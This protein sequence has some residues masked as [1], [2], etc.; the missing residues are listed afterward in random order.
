MKLSFLVIDSR[1]DVHSNWVNACIQSLMSM[2]KNNLSEE[3]EIVIVPN[4]GR[5]MTIG[6]AWNKGVQECTGDWIVFI[7]DDDYVAPDYAETLDKWIRSE[8]VQKSNIVNVATYMYA[9]NEEDGNSFPMTRQST[10]AWKK[11][12]LLKHPF[13]E[14]LKKGIDREY[15]EEMIKRGDLSLIITYYF[16]YFY[17]RHNDYRCAGDIIFHKEESDFYFVTSDRI[18]L[19]PIEERLKKYGSVFIDNNFDLKLVSKA[20]VVWCEWANQK[21]IEISNTPLN[22]LKVLRL[23]AYEAFTEYAPQINWNGFDVVIIIGEHIKEYLERQYGKINGAVVIPNGVDLN[24]FTLG[25]KVRNNKIAVAGYLTRK[26]GIGE[27]LLIAK[28]LPE[29]EFHLAGKYQENDIADWMNHKKPDNVF[30]HEWKYEDALNE[31]YQDKTY[32]MNNSMRESQ[33][34]SLME[35]MACGLKPITNDWIGAKEIYGEEYVYKNLNDIVK[36]LRSEYEPEKYRKFI[37]DNYD[38]EKIVNLIVENL[39]IKEWQLTK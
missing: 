26:K 11:D 3:F 20:K 21:A 12:Y 24:K 10:G 29:Y 37:E 1:S 4:L 9:F 22:G 19:T 18:F 2:D 36:I 5:T 28:S 38:L 15:V 30:I 34:M 6:E 35:G 32:I 13:N 33:S 31:F 23:H 17:R 25:E 16:G 7:G 27:L 39:G 8:Q 14:K